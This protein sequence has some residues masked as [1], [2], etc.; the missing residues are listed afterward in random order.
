[1]TSRGDAAGVGAVSGSDLVPRA[2]RSLGLGWP[3]HVARGGGPLKEHR[4]GGGGGD[5]VEQGQGQGPRCAPGPQLWPQTVPA[6]PQLPPQTPPSPPPAWLFPPTCSPQTRCPRGLH[7]ASPGPSRSCTSSSHFLRE[8]GAPVRSPPL[9]SAGSQAP[10]HHSHPEPPCPWLG[11]PSPCFPVPSPRRERPPGSKEGA[12]ASLGKP[13]PA[14]TRGVGVLQARG[15]RCCP[16]VPTPGRRPA[17]LLR[18]VC[19]LSRRYCPHRG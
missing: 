4:R 12:C 5:G 11:G 19:G 17:L 1:M 6:G 16:G 18:G 15:A 10:P 8:L 14:L 13:A 2:G 9:L 7:A 3:C